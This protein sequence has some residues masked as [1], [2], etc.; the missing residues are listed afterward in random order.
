MSVSVVEAIH[1]ARERAAPAEPVERIQAIAGRGLEGDRHFGDHER[2]S[3]HDLTLVAAESVEALAEEQGIVLEPGQTRRQITTRGVDVN[4][5]V[6]RRF[7]VGEVEA[8]GIEL[9]EPC[10]HL[11]S[12]TPPGT[13]RGLV[14]RAGINADIVRDGQIAVGDPVA[15]QGDC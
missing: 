7:T 11:Q 2:G 9:C 1:I 12:L 3:G 4:A 13:M 8:V 15:D 5:L 14:H 10:S 6:G